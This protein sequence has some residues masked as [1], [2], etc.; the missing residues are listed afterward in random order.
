LSDFGET[1]SEETIPKNSEVG[2]DGNLYYV[3]IKNSNTDE[4]D[5]FPINKNE[6]SKIIEKYYLDQENVKIKYGLTTEPIV[7]NTGHIAYINKKNPNGKRFWLYKQNVWENACEGDGCVNYIVQFTTTGLPVFSTQFYKTGFFV[8]I[9]P[10]LPILG[11]IT[12][13]VGLPLFLGDAI[14][15]SVGATVGNTALS[16]A[17]GNIAINTTLSGGDIG[18]ALTKDLIKSAGGFVGD[19]VGTGVDSVDVGRIAGVAA[20]A[21]ISGKN[22][23]NAAALTAATLGIKMLGDDTTDFVDTTATDWASVDT[24][25][26]FNTNTEFASLTLNDL[27]IDVDAVTL[28]DSLAENETVLANAGIDINSVLPDSKGNLFTPDGKFVELD[29]DTYAK[30]IYVDDQ[31]N[32]RGPD[33]EIIIPANDAAQ[34]DANTMTKKIVADMEAKAGQIQT[35]VAAPA[36]RPADIP[37]AAAQ[38]KSPT[39][40]DQ[41]STFDKVLKTAVSIGASI[42]AIANGTFRPTYTTSAFGTPRVQSVG[43]PITQSDGSTITNNGNGTQTIRYPNGQTTTTSTSF[44]GSNA[45]G[46]T[47]AGIPSSTLLIGGGVLLA[48][49]LLS[50]K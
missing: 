37:P 7:V 50:R 35:T 47:I 40:S 21:A 33:N 8:D 2:F 18:A 10:F 13:L 23:L 20:T 29:A 5:Q 28:S 41:A 34:M 49:I 19:F 30:S 12:T 32:V 43:V 15:G 14:L 39:I 36:S 9:A 48:A 3:R 44:I 4:Y 27:G 24:T 16:T 31:G 17:V 42:K 1:H 22:P 26:W 46:G 25:T 45:F 6:E 11:L 38:T